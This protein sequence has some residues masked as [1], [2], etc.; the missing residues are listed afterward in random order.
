MKRNPRV[1]PLLG[2]VLSGGLIVS[3]LTAVT[4][5]SS[6]TAAT[7]GDPCGVSG[8][9][10]GSTCTYDRMG[11]DTFTLPDG[12]NSVRVIVTGA[13][14]GRYYLADDAAHGGS[15]TGDITCGVCA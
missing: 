15:P 13:Q 5:S 6:S 1:L 8:V 10:S 14:G 11:S 12:V 3:A 4:L 9:L 7:V 2:V